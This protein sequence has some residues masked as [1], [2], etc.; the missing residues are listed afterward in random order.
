VS[1][2][3]VRRRVGRVA[4]DRVSGVA[5]DREVGTCR[6]VECVIATVNARKRNNSYTLVSSLYV[7][8][9][10]KMEKLENCYLEMVE[11]RRPGKV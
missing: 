1:V 7:R 11:S 10:K 5:R 2:F 3:R 8:Y 9:W 6:W 4:V